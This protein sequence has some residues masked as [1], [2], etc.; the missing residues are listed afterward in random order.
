MKYCVRM[1]ETQEE[2]SL[3]KVSHEKLNKDLEKIIACK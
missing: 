1:L 3:K 2:V